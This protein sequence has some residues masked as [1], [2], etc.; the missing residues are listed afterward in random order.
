M[1][2]KSLGRNQSL[3][4]QSPKA[5]FA[6]FLSTAKGTSDSGRMALSFSACSSTREE[7]QKVQVVAVTPSE[8]ATLAPHSWHLELRTS[9]PAASPLGAAASPWKK[10]YSTIVPVPVGTSR[11]APQ[12]PHLSLPSAASY[13]CS[14]AHSLQVKRCDL[15]AFS[16]S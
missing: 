2:F 4:S 8:K 10:S 7:P 11:D 14:A 15:T 5:W 6:R 16:T 3:P 9:V 13:F 12:W 1:R